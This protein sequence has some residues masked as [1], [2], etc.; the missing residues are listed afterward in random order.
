[1][2]TAGWSVVGRSHQAA[3][4]PVG[5]VE[6]VGVVAAGGPQ[7]GGLQAAHQLALPVD[8]DVAAGNV[9][10]LVGERPVDELRS[11]PG[12]GH[13]HRPTGSEHPGQLG[14]GLLVVGD[15]L[16]HL[17]GDDPVERAVLE[18]QGQGVALDGAHPGRVEVELAVHHHGPEGVQHVAHLVGPGVECHHLGTQAGGLIGVAAEA[19]PE[20]EQAV[21]GAHTQTGVVDGQ[22]D[23]VSMGSFT[24]SAHWPGASRQHRRAGPGIR[25]QCRRR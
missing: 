16:Q 5:G 24:S 4:P 3:E 22:H 7:S 11:A 6:A 18:G 10:V 9:V 23:A 21:T 1:M 20:V 2:E 13:G 14:H 25:P 15:V 17:G 12:H 19:A 8:A